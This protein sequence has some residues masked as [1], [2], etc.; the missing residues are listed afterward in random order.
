MGI[1]KLL[2]QYPRLNQTKIKMVIGKYS[3]VSFDV[4][5]TLLKRDVS[6]PE[7]VFQLAEMKYNT[8]H[9][10]PIRNF[11]NRRTAAEKAAREKQHG[12]EVT[13]QEIYDEFDEEMDELMS[14][15]M[16]IEMQVSCVNP[17]I[18]EIYQYCIHTKKKV[19]II[20]DTYL[21]ST[22]IKELLHKN[23]ITEYNGLYVSSECG[24]MKRYGELYRYVLDKE[25]LDPRELVHIGDNKRAD[26]LMPKKLGIHS[27]CIPKDVSNTEYLSHGSENI[28]RRSL[29]SYINNRLPYCKNRNFAIGYE[30]Y[31][32]LLY[33]F[34]KWLIS[35]VNTEK[36]ILFFARDC[37][38]VK[39]AFEK[40]DKAEQYKSTY[41][42]A[43]RKSLI[44]PIL[45]E[46]SSL[47]QVEKLIIS[48]PLRL[49]LGGLLNKFGLE[50]DKYAAHAEKYG[51]TLETIL[52]RNKLCENKSLARFWDDIV[53]IV[54]QDVKRSHNLFF[55]Y[56]DRFDFTDEI[57]VV[58]IGWRGT[59]QYCLKNL[60]PEKYK[61]HGYYLGVRE[62][63]LLNRSEY[64][65]FYL[66]GEDDEDKRVFLASVSALIEIFFSAPHGSVKGYDE[67]G[68]A[69][70]D[71]WECSDDEK[72][73][74]LLR[75]LH[76]GALKFIDDFSDSAISEIINVGPDM[77]FD[78]LKRMGKKPKKDELNAFSD[79]PF[80][81]G[82]GTVKA[83]A[84][85]K[86]R[87]YMI[88]PKKASH[89]FSNS[90]WKIAFMMKLFKIK[91][92]YY[93]IFK[94]IYRHKG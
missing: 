72:S 85:D 76:E 12:K 94:V 9:S 92:P 1:K 28:D 22:V 87:R 46:N 77:I 26:F 71:K 13:L 5:D 10:S 23:G 41:F 84:T 81:M 36:S 40:M 38:V 47:D 15:E 8:E 63:T 20:S 90:N 42:L 3:A 56:F 49:T 4:F 31:G 35:K 68:S 18:E 62:D 32:P 55:E 17:L 57:Q 11:K 75:D 65:G 30:I 69:V 67:S 70:Y 93:G 89:D 16:A 91:L 25:G 43:S 51:L 54:K 83:A 19:Y 50:S 80:Q 58:D 14:I 61:I 52:Q 7:D 33:G 73:Q 29:F 44:V 88:D 2:N 53:P 66:D 24:V 37:H 64:D 39:Q 48:E 34:V 79:F 45:Y 78:G 74:C 21:G 60:L 59:M 86:L 82:V 6:F 27:I